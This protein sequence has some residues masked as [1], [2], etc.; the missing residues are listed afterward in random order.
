MAC[1]LCASTKLLSFDL[2]GLEYEECSECGYIGIRRRFFPDRAAEESRYRLHRNDLSEP[3]Y[4]AYLS[5]FVDQA[6]APYLEP[7][8]SVLDFGSGPAPAL[9]MLLGERGYRVVAYD[10]YF[11]PATAWRRRSWKGIAVHEVAE[12]LRMPG[13]TLAALS[14][15]LEPGG[16]MALRTRFPPA[17]RG[18]FESWWYRQDATHLGFFRPISFSRFAERLGLETPLI[19]E[20]DIVVLR[21]PGG[22]QAQPRVPPGSEALPRALGHA[23]PRG[24]Y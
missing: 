3:G 18:E 1:R 15:R 10:P 13:R 20:P 24:L 19:A 17:G 9:A 16:I 4:R 5:A 21:A 7:G 6:L 23:I 22:R 2:K 12:H 14:R 11:A 8:D